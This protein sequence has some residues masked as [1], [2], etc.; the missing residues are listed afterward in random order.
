MEWR[1]SGYCPWEEEKHSEYKYLGDCSN[2][3]NNKDK[4]YTQFY[5]KQV[6]KC[7]KMKFT[8]GRDD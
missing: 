5:L 4:Q 3:G 8:K 2:Y 1:P 6:G 7:Q